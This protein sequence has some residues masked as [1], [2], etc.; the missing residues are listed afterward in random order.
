MTNVMAIKTIDA[1]IESLLKKEISQLTCSNM[2]IR[3]RPYV[4]STDTGDN[5]RLPAWGESTM[6]T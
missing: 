6:K 2:R 4:I 1:Q 3:S 5:E